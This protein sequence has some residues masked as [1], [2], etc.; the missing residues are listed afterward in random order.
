MVLGL[1]E[2]NLELLRRV[3]DADR[4]EFHGLLTVEELQLGDEIPV[5]DLLR[6]AESRISAFDGRVDAIVG[7]WDF[8]VSTLVPVLCRPGRAGR[9]G[10][11]G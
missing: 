6:K 2:T 4:Y 9:A 3:P 1:D 8:P 11:L 10:P 5:A 7:F